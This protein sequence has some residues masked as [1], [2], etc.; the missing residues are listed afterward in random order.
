MM[1]IQ[2]PNCSI[3][4]GAQCHHAASQIPPGRGFRGTAFHQQSL[5]AHEIGHNNNAEETSATLSK[6]VCWLFDEECAD[7]LMQ[8][9]NGFNGRD[10]F[11]Y[12]SQDAEEFIG[13]ILRERLEPASGNP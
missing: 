9:S 7:A 6:P 5:V 11:L 3:G 13:P 2:G 4:G 8:S 12:Y 10:L 1:P